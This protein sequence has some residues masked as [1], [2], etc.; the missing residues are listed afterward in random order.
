MI[1]P[2]QNIP[3]KEC[4]NRKK[5]VTPFKRWMVQKPTPPSRIYPYCWSFVKR[6]LISLSYDA[7]VYRERWQPNVLKRVRETVNKWEV[8]KIGIPSY[9]LW[10]WTSYF[11]SCFVLFA[12]S[13]AE[14]TS[15]LTGYRCCACG[16]LWEY[17]LFQTASASCVNKG[18]RCPK[19]KKP[20]Y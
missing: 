5:T 17:K 1:L 11:R 9:S 8:R 6:Y 3:R 15:T 14:C 12:H 4:Q 19:S 20:L 18:E 16:D 10:S 7:V 13:S 2:I